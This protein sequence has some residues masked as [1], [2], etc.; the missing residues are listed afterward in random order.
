MMINLFQLG[1]EP[2]NSS[3]A[4]EHNAFPGTPSDWHSTEAG[5]RNGIRISNASLDIIVVFVNGNV[6]ELARDISSL[7]GKYVPPREARWVAGIFVTVILSAFEG[8]TGLQD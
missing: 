2:A 8:R 6:A 5:I 4:T 7:T 3:W 1:T